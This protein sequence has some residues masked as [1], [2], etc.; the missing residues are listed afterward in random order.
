MA[1]FWAERECKRLFSLYTDSE[2]KTAVLTAYGNYAVDCKRRASERSASVSP[3]A[4][5]TES[6]IARSH[7]AGRRHSN[8][9]AFEEQEQGCSLVRRSARVVK[10]LRQRAWSLEN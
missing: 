1:F 4:L 9:T 3:I 10:K 2:R 6:A 5:T 8:D 7:F